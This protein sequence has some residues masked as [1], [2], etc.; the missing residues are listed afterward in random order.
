MI[1]SLVIWIFSLPKKIYQS[2]KKIIK[3][4]FFPDKKKGLSY[5]KKQTSKKTR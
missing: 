5:V 1:T 3:Y 2:L 4:L